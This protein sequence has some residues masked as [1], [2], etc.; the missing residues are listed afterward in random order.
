M[1]LPANKNITLLV[2]DSHGF[3]IIG[4]EGAGIF[5]ELVDYKNIHLIVISSFG[6]AFGIPGGVVLSDKQTIDNFKNNPFF[7]GSS[8]VIPAYLYAFL[9]SE[10]IYKK[11]REKL[12]ANIRMFESQIS[13]FGLFSNF[14]NYPVFYT[15]Q[16]KLCT[17]LKENQILISSF[18]YPSPEDTQITRV[19]INSLHTPQ[20]INSLATSVMAFLNDKVT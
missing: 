2:D 17:Y 12:F 15:P 16:N 8:P 7:G 1:Q 20:D 3:G 19:I 10:T 6:K 4:K 9:Q 14:T 13:A 18:P 5:S 11:E